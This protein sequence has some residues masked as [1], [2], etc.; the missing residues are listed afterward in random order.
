MAETRPELVLASSSRFRRALLEA[1]GIAVRVVPP[2]VD[3][4]AIRTALARRGD[5]ISASDVA[6]ILARAKAEEISSEDASALVLGAD[7]VLAHGD[8]IFAKPPSAEA[9]RDQLL[10]LAGKTHQLHSAIVLAVGG[11]TVWSHVSTA[12]MTMRA[13]TPAEIGRYLARVGTAAMD[14]VGAYQ[15][16]REGVHLFERIDGDHF[17]IIG[18]PVLPLSAELRRRGWELP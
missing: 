17:T 7:Q 11:E 15:I 14:S 5:D 9:A 8:K 1:A 4:T 6:E 3:E 10:E 12:H 2:T 18:L 13:L 16:E